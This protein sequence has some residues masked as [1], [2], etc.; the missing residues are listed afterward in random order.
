FIFAPSPRRV[1]RAAVREII[2]ELPAGVTTM[3]VFVDTETEEIRAAVEECGLSGVQLHG[4]E[5]PAAM[6][7]PGAALV[8]K[9]FRIREAADLEAIPAFTGAAGGIFLDAY[10]PGLAGGS[11]KTFDWTLAAGLSRFGVPVILA[12]GL[13]PQNVSQAILQGQPDVVDVSSGVESSPGKKDHER[14]RSFIRAV[15]SADR[16]RRFDTEG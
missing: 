7:I 14:V 6:R 12:G 10:A 8:W 15:R 9:A 5:T 16:S 4:Q 3:G 13:N 11:G 2:A 1:S